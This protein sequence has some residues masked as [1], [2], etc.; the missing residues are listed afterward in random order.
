MTKEIRWKMLVAT[1][2]ESEAALLKN[3]LE[4]EGIRCRL[5]IRRGFPG[6][7]HGGKTV[8]AEI[9]VPLEDFEASQQI[10]D[11]GEM[12]EEDGR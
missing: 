2:E 12:D 7:P 4:S 8:E 5:Q 11:L 1:S 10:V 9:Y 3:R 6:A